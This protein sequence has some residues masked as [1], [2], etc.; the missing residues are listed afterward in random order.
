[1]PTILPVP[2]KSIVAH[3]VFDTA[4]CNLF[5]NDVVDQISPNIV[6]CCANPK[7]GDFQCDARIPLFSVMKKQGSLPPHILSP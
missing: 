2:G 1:M 7:H 5:G 6:G 3:Y 4:I